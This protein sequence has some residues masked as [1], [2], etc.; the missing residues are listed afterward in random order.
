MAL[1]ERVAMGAIMFMDTD[2]ALA[3][4]DLALRY[5]FI[6]RDQRTLTRSRQPTNTTSSSMRSYDATSR[7]CSRD[8]IFRCYW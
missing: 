3:V 5:G 8:N 6:D 4:V 1:G 7:K 2:A